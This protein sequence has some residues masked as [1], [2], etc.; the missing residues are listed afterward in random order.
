M[1]FA[2]S[3]KG[4]KFKQ[5]IFCF[6]NLFCKVYNVIKVQKRKFIIYLWLKMINIT[7]FDN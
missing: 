5:F 1:R 4:I 3:I 7:L 6:I 2:N